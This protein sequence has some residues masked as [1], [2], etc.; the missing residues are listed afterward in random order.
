MWDKVTHQWLRIP[1]TLHVRTDKKVKKPRA[2]VLFLHGIG[3]SGASWDSVIERLPKDIRLVTIDLLGFGE[4]RQ[5]RWATYDA[6][7]QAHAVLATY[8]KLRISGQVIIVGHSLGGLIAVE[9]TKR[10]PLLVKELILY[11]PP[12][13]KV[14]ET[15]RR[16]IPSAD[17][18][19]RDLYGLVKNHPEEFLKITLLAAKFG[20]VN[21]SFSVTKDTVALY[22]NALEASIINQT[23]LEDAV[24]LK[25]PIHILHGRFDTVV[26]SKNLQYLAK[27]NSNVTVTTVTAAHEVVGVIAVKAVAKAVDDAIN[28]HQPATMV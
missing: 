21:K 9:I 25:V 17:K 28:R 7:I 19:L 2:T 1:Y 18:L 22:M 15:K 13:Y 10:Y 23:S 11:G 5:P 16:L 14:D 12:F 20:L 26:I 24:K 3:N 8:L 6:K 27:R 4:S